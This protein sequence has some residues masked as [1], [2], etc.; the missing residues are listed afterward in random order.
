MAS[1]QRAVAEHIREKRFTRESI[2]E[3]DLYAQWATFLVSRGIDQAQAVRQASL[4]AD[5]TSM[6]LPL[7]VNVASLP[8]APLLA[9]AAD[10]EVELALPP[11]E[12]QPSFEVSDPPDLPL[13]TFVTSIQPS[14]FRRLHCI[15]SCSRLPGVDYACFEVLGMIEPEVG[16][17]SKR[18]KQCFKQ[19]AVD[20]PS[21]SSSEGSSSSYGSSLS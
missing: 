8:A 20:Q 14:G 4:L 18:C 2:G 15:G 17:Y 9:E 1:V 19:D 7:E 13:G 3:V 12:E 16:T 21:S 5:A 6:I 11:S 10:I